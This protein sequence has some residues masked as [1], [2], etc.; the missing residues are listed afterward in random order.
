MESGLLNRTID[1]RIIK[2]GFPSLYEFVCMEIS[3]VNYH[4]AYFIRFISF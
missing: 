2:T 4:S 1:L 3:T